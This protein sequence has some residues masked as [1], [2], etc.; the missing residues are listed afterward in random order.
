[1]S[2]LAPLKGARIWLSGAMPEG[3]DDAETERF[4]A[5]LERISARI[6]KDGGSIVH[7]SHPSVVDALL[8]SATTYQDPHGAKGKRDCLMLAASKIYHKQNKTKLDRWRRNSE[9]HEEPL[10]DGD[11]DKSM[12]RLR[13]WMADHCDAVIAVGGR[14]W[15]LN[16][17]VAG[18]PKEFDL[19][20]ERGLPCFLLAG[21]SGAAAGYLRANSKA[22]DNLKNGLDEA[23]NRELAEEQNVD[24]LVNRV[25]EQLGRLPLVRGEPLGKTTFRILALDGSG[26]KGTFTAAVL[27]KWEE[28]TQLRLAEHTLI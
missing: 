18:I 16:P 2:D 23:G 19:A 3:V 13:H 21:L 11:E 26:I 8:R 15:K 22:L 7:G 20:R 28:L 24:G 12:A 25:V 4:T 27:A 10:V 5:F 1:M 6:F 14:R 9:V 17:S